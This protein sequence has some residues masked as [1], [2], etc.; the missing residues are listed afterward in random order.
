MDFLNTIGL[1][2]VKVGLQDII[3]KDGHRISR[4]LA[5]DSEWLHRPSAS[6]TSSES[7]FEALIR[8]L[9]LQHGDGEY[10]NLPLRYECLSFF[11]RQFPAR[12][13]QTGGF[14][15]HYSFPPR[16][17]L[18]HLY[19]PSQLNQFKP[20]P[21]EEHTALLSC[22]GQQRDVLTEVIF[23]LIRNRDW[24]H[25]P[26]KRGTQT[27]S[28]LIDDYRSRTGFTDPRDRIYGMLGLA[29]DVG[30]LGIEVDYAKAWEDVYTDAFKRTIINGDGSDWKVDSVLSMVRFP[31]TNDLLPSW[32][33]DLNVTHSIAT[34]SVTT[35]LQANTTQPFAAAASTTHLP[36]SAS[37]DPPP[38][39]LTCRGITV[40]SVHRVGRQWEWKEEDGEQGLLGAFLHCSDIATYIESTPTTPNHPHAASPARRAEGVWRIPVIDH[41]YIDASIGTSRR[42]TAASFQAYNDVNNMHLWA[43]ALM[44]GQDIADVVPLNDEQ[45]DELE[46]VSEHEREA[47]AQQMRV[48]RLPV[49]PISAN[50]Y[51]SR[52][53]VM[54]YRRPFV[55]KG[56][57]VSL[58]P[59]GMDVGDLVCVLYGARV[60]F[61][62]RPVKGKGQDSEGRKYTLVGECYCDGI[63]D[64]EALKM[65]LEEE[66]IKIV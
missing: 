2:G 21:V 26:E 8:K 35:L 32:V 34:Q 11:K 40:D 16:A 66:V 12:L 9:I 17:L 30:T 59:S 45:Q 7:A 29:C 56:G 14:R 1:E 18:N 27:L 49:M 4:A 51:F 37:S 6:A 43:N 38:H 13:D 64:G 23:P 54:Q 65:G 22:L 39:I 53:N 63:M 31:K 24:F 46:R 55:G 42:C 52:M 57:F 28:Y 61:V 19:T 15:S 5:T 60:P 58:G 3:D 47:K 41:E 36:P 20:L 48:E 50:L 25:N 62:L 33:P 44:P 10:G